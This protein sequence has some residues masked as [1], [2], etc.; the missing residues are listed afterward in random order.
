M[1]Q[2]YHNTN[3]YPKKFTVC[4]DV[5]NRED[6]L[7]LLLTPNNTIEIACG[8]AICSDSDNYSRKIGRELSSS[9]KKELPFQLL[10]AN[11]NINRQQNK[12]EQHHLLVLVHK[13]IIV[14]IILT[15]YSSRP[16][17]IEAILD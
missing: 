9:R 3:S 10:H 2:F 7:E 14:K 8:Y 12:I 13:N 11:S 4:L 1:D 17:F 6:L 5:P 16:M 15:H